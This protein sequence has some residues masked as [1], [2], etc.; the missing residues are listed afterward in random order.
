MSANQ[1]VDAWRRQLAATFLGD[2][3]KRARAVLAL[4]DVNRFEPIDLSFGLV[5]KVVVGVMHIDVLGIAAAR[6]QFDGEQRR[7]LGR[8]W[9]VGVVGMERLAR[10]DAFAVHDLVVADVVHVGITRNVCWSRITRTCRSAKARA[11]AAR[12]SLSI[13][14]VKSRPVTSAPV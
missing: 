1:R 8:A 4:I 13:G 2:F 14:W 7:S 10:D 6:R 9:V 5:G 12:V 11:S 3:S